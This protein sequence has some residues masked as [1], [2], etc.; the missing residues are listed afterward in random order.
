MTQTGDVMTDSGAPGPS[1]PVGTTD[2][3]DP[4]P[5]RVTPRRPHPWRS[6]AVAGAGYLVVSVVVWWNVWSGHPTSTTTC[7]CGDTS[8][9][10]WF[11]E[12]PAYAMAHGHSPL[13]SAAMHSPSGVNLLANTSVL[14]VGTVLAPVTWLFGPVASL[15][16]ALT[17][18]PVLSALA[19]FV[20]LRRWV[21]WTPAAF[22]GGLFYGFS[23]FILVSLT[24]AHLM[25]GLV[26]VPPLV[27]LCLDEL[28]VRQRRRPVPVGIGLGLLITV[29]F[30]IGSE[31]LLITVLMSTLGLL[32][33]VLHAAWRRT[34]DLRAHLRNAGVGLASGAVTAVVLL[35]GPVWYALSGPA[36]LG[37][38][39]W[40]GVLGSIF[41]KNGTVLNNYLVGVPRI[42]GLI[43][44]DHNRQVGG[45][46]GPD[47]SYQYFG[48]V[49]LVVLAVGWAVWHRDRRLWLFGSVGLVS[50]VLSLGTQ[51][52]IWS[53]LLRLPLLE[54][55]VPYRFVLVTYLAASVML[56]LIV[57]H[58]HRTVEARWGASGTDPGATTVRRG[59]R[60][61]RTAAVVAAATALLVAALALAQ[62]AAYVAQTIP[63]TVTPVALPSWFRTVAPGLHGHQV[64]LIVPAPFTSFDNAMTWQ[65]VDHMSFS[66][67]TEG[68]PG[69]VLLRAGATG[70]D[71]LHAAT[72]LASLSSSTDLYATF[73]TPGIIAMGRALH[74]WGV[75][76]VVLPDQAGLPQ[77]DQVASVS[78]AVAAITAATG[79]RPVRQAGAWVWADV[80]HRA[81]PD[82]TA[83]DRVAA[84]TT[85][86]APDGVAAVD[87][88]LGCVLATPSARSR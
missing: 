11:I 68:G 51:A 3:P 26:P 2:S 7:G 61:G 66:M 83:A 64:L 81:H 35:A 12:W 41:T 43:A 28:A 46:Q 6:L 59:T 40:P 88:V 55:I 32:L 74:E 33:V 38:T 36:S 31:V 48:I 49:I 72:V 52:H 70:S 47:L 54:N 45:Y 76:M 16:V 9:F 29:Q 75:T 71:Q 78:P 22:I 79:Q 44:L 8:L 85:G 19:M 27:V 56:G 50:V 18:A 53:L 57:D 80:D 34:P 69:G 4:T 24:D 86:A 14:A 73:T 23:P 67:V 60:P 37:G 30:F 5:T 62:P 65:A 21:R 25:L 84:C 63:M 10:T 39:V 87:H 82:A 1:Q 77:Y 42:T 13:Y 20:L 17:L 15:N 58:V